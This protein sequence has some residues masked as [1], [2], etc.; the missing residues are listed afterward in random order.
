MMATEVITESLEWKEGVDL[1]ANTV[2]RTLGVKGKSVVLDTNNF[3]R[4]NIT[5]DGVTIARAVNDKTR[6]KNIGVKLIKEAAEKTND[7]AGDGTTTTMIL[8]QSIVESG[9]K[10]IASGADGI[11]LRKGIVKATE[12]LSEYLKTERVSA[13]DLQSLASVA[14][15]SCRDPKIG[16]LVAEVVKHAGKEGI[17]TLEDR[18]E[19]DTIYEK[20]EGLK[21]AGGFLS[22][23]Y[24]NL[25]ERQQTVFKDTLI[26]TTNRTITLGDE[27]GKIMEVVANSGKKEAVVI[28]NGIDGPALMTSFINW[29]NQAIYILPIRV[30]TYGDLGLGML[31]D[32]AAIT[33]ATFLDENEK[34]LSEITIEDFGF[35]NKIVVD[36]HSTTVIADDESLK[37]ERIKQLKSAMDGS[38]EFERENIEQRIAKLNS[39]MF[40]IKVG[41]KTDTERNELKTRIDDAVKASK[42]ALE[43]GVIA[44]GGS[45]LYRASKSVGTPDITSNEGI[46]EKLVYDSCITPIKQMA[47]N[48]RIELDRSDF[49][50]IKNKEKAIDFKDGQV[51]DAFNNGIID[52]LKVVLECLQNAA[53]QAGIFL[54]LDAAVITIDPEKTETI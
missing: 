51:V 24:V 21:L 28:A 9:M 44:G 33:G 23:E 41:G 14:T 16:E 11:D 20:Q 12:L 48:S 22:E 30:I 17:V 8:M 4:L 42:A 2:K 27:M 5:N 39:A 1:V 15:I 35:A 3:G 13:E 50:A 45:A 7:N 53:A 43:D 18:L 10:A 6:G 49:E 26:L 36:K 46:G 19:T 52:P 34:N 29:K 38:S 47:I 54:T 37:K 25:P 40:T 32:V 31:K